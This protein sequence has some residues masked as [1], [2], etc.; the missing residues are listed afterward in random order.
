M[1]DVIIFPGNNGIVPRTTVTD[2]EDGNSSVD[3]QATVEY[4]PNQPDSDDDDMSMRT[5]DSDRSDSTID[6]TQGTDDV[7]VEISFENGEWS[8]KCGRRNRRRNGTCRNCSAMRRW[9]H[10]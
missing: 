8:C 6:L 1:N 3:S 10:T 2:D 7:P 4:V 9:A 5:I